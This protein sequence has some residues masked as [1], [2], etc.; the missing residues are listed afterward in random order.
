MKKV[1][2]KIIENTSL[3]RHLQERKERKSLKRK[4]EREARKFIKELDEIEFSDDQDSD[5]WTY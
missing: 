2:K 3:G 5:E 4:E 1:L